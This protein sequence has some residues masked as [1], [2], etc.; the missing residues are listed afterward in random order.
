[1]DSYSSYTVRDSGVVAAMIAVLVLGYK[2][3]P[4]DSVETFSRCFGSSARARSSSRAGQSW[5]EWVGTSTG[6]LCPA[7]HRLRLKSDRRATAW[8]FNSDA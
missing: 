4:Q 7:M 6:L 1:M 2:S 8:E 3:R 5:D